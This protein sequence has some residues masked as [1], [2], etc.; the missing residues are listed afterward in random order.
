MDDLLKYIYLSTNV[1]YKDL[2][3]DIKLNLLLI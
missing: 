2:G 1:E 3:L